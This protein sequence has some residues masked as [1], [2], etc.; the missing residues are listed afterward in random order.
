MFKLYVLY[1]LRGL[2]I[3]TGIDFEGV[4]DTASY[5]A[6]ELGKPPASR[7]ARALTDWKA[8]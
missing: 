6:S 4:L 2:D 1:M 8:A 7:V 5:I 3:E